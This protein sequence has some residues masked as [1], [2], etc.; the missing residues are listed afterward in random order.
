MN[1]PNLDPLAQVSDAPNIKALAEEF[2]RAWS[3]QLQ[4][5]AGRLSG[6]AGIATA[7]DIRFCR[8][9]GQTPDGLKDQKLLPQGQVARPYDGA[10]DTRIPFADET[11]NAIVDVLYASFWNGR[12]NTK[13]TH[14]SRLTAQQTAEWRAVVSWLVHGSLK[15]KLIKLVDYAAQMAWSFGHV[16][17]HPTWKVRYGLRTQK[18]DLNEILQFAAAV[19]DRESI[20]AKI[21][22]L[23]M[24]PTLEDE[25]VELCERIYPSLSTTRARRVVRDLR[26]TPEH[27]AE[28]PVPE[29]QENGPDIDV[30]LSWVDLIYPPET[31]DIQNCRMPTVRRFLTET[32][33]EEMANEL[34]P[35]DV[36][37]NRDFCDAV[38]N[39]KG[40]V[41]DS[42]AIAE[43]SRD[44]NSQLIE[45]LYTFVKGID[46]ETG[47]PAIYCTIWSAWLA[48]DR[49]LW[50][51]A[52][53]PLYAQ[54]Y[55]VDFAHN[56]YPLVAYTT[57][58]IGKREDD[59]RGV[60]EILQTIQTE[61]KRQYDGLAV[62][63][64]L[65][66]TPPLRAPANS[67]K[68]PPEFGP[69]A[70]MRQTP[71]AGEWN[72]VQLTAGAQ[73]EIAFQLIEDKRKWRD[74]Y[75]GLPRPDTHPARAQARLQ[76]LVNRWLLAWSECLWQL[77]VLAYQ[78]LEPDELFQILGRQPML[79]AED[80]LRHRLALTFDVRTMDNDWVK[81]I[82][83]NIGLVLQWDRGGSTDTNKLVNF[84]YSLLDPTLQ[85]EVTLDQA[86]AANAVFE[87]VLSDIMAIMDG[88]KPMLV[89]NDPTAQMK[90]RFAQQIVS[91][92]P[93][94]MLALMEQFPNGQ[95][96]PQFNP[97]LAGNFQ[98]YMDNL[99]HNYQEMVTSKVQGR[100]G[101]ADVG[102]APIT[103]GS[104]A[105]G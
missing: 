46:R 94:Y 85:D 90:L 65:S 58:V 16:W 77:S 17:L 76:R 6:L 100:L 34:L 18:L 26:E 91:G 42:K 2:S 59:A 83:A 37:W 56:Q 36:R 23:I 44:E 69:L 62:F 54:H 25:A 64:E 73:P 55:L 24:D 31:S 87:K 98:T 1:E 11:I 92:N 97:M 79:T 27:K 104:G 40:L 57:E 81:E 102:P 86:G 29:L 33:V 28:F 53:D 39:T 48:G 72:P 88:N 68:L 93:K 38:K 45:V 7:E 63:T 60:P 103:Q 47:C 95:P 51:D 30:L 89:E 15:G 22:M 43:A 3:Q 99:Q 71:G 84:M 8:W 67:S 75:F 19:P 105:Q 12:I 14:I 35:D 10:P 4:S 9:S 20:L 82:V 21:P 50:N 80:L 5:Q 41:S 13:P 66:L 32:Q 52:E 49:R 74:E 61:V 96:N 70:I 101:V 78:N